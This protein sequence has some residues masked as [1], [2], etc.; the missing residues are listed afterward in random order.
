MVQVQ[1]PIREKEGRKKKKKKRNGF[2]M[3][4]LQNL[5]DRRRDS[6]SSATL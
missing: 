6:H 2:T 5:L 3:A 4:S 1:V